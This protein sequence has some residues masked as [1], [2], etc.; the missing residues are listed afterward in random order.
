MPD[1][2]RDYQHGHRSTAPAVLTSVVR[3]RRIR[4]SHVVD[5]VIGQLFA[6]PRPLLLSPSEKSMSAA[7]AW[8]W[9]GAIA[10]DDEEAVGEEKEPLA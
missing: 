8:R 3:R 6:R 2:A 9:R 1:G 5:D 4:R 7:K 10:T